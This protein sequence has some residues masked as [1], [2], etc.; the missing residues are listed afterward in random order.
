MIVK[1]YVILRQIEHDL[2]L[3]RLTEYFNFIMRFALNVEITSLVTGEESNKKRPCLFRQ[4]ISLES[5][6]A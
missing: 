1:V 3:N 2:G 6:T 4:Q 5:K